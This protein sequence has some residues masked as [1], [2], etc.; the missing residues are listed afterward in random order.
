KYVVAEYNKGNNKEPLPPKVYGQPKK[1][2][3][4]DLVGLL[5][6]LILA[7]NTSNAPLFT[8]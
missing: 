3:D 2:L 7:A 4:S 6:S 1:K 8:S 5:C